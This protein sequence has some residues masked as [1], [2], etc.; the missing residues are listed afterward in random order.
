[1]ASV[2]EAYRDEKGNLHYEPSSA[3]VADIA[4]ALGRVGD[5]GGLTEG[6]ARLILEKRVAIEKAFS[7][8]DRLEGNSLTV[9]DVSDHLRV[10]SISA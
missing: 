9:I 1:M 5:E 10:Q 8:L 3:I 2:I 6:V 7:D 4:A